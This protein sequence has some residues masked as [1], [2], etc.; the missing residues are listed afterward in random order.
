M[1]SYTR[2]LT[3]EKTGRTWSNTESRL[4]KKRGEILEQHVEDMVI[5]VNRWSDTE[6]TGFKTVILY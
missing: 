3:L 4:L 5:S 6:S 1:K 2:R